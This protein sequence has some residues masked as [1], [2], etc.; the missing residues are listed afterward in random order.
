MS[1]I[2]FGVLVLGIIALSGLFPQPSYSGH[3]QF[4]YLFPK[5]VAAKSKTKSV[6][7]ITSNLVKVSSPTIS[8]KPSVK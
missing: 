1:R 2:L 8:Q 7:G 4:I 3:S 5:D 6:L